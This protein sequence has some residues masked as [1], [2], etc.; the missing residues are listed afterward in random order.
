MN[1]KIK[2]WIVNLE[3]RLANGNVKLK[4]AQVKS[5]QRCL[6]YASSELAKD[7]NF[8]EVCSE[9]NAL[10]VQINTVEKVA[11]I[12]D[13]YTSAIV[14]SLK[15]ALTKLPEVSKLHSATNLAHSPSKAFI[16]T[17]YTYDYYLVTDLEMTCIK[18]GDDSSGFV[19]E[20]IEI[21]CEVVCSKLL[22]LLTHL[23]LW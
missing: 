2:D 18:N 3:D 6:S 11:F 9:L 8:N 22:I 19:M 10:T 4:K 1:N 5:I 13:D 16:K 15:L 21:G 12:S 14:N 17:A 23:N 20:T 7:G